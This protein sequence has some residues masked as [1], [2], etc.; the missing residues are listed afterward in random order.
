MLGFLS[1]E[2]NIR[3]QHHIIFPGVFYTIAYGTKNIILFPP[4]AIY[5]LFYIEMMRIIT[6]RV[7]EFCHLPVR[8]LWLNVTIYRTV[9][10]PALALLC[11]FFQI[12]ASLRF[13]VIWV[14]PIFFFPIV[15]YRLGTWWIVVVNII[16][17]SPNKM[18]KKN[19][20]YF[21]IAK[22]EIYPSKLTQSKK[23]NRR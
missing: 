17:L 6:R 14:F 4:F 15:S 19:P 23:F 8:S 10:T 3:G 11:F 2:V 20:I 16:L 9:T 12:L 22:L 21:Q 1:Q 18:K 13:L 5:L 7:N